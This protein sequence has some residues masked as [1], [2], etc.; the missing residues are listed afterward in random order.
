MPSRAD[1]ICGLLPLLLTTAKAC[2]SDL[3]CS[4]NGRCVSSNCECSDIWTGLACDILKTSQPARIESYGGQKNFASWGGNVIAFGGKFHLYVA[5][6]V[7]QCGL[8][9]WTTNSQIVHATSDTID[10]PFEKEDVAVAPWA[11]NPQIVH[12]PSHLRAGGGDLFVL[13]HIGD[14]TGSETRDCSKS[15]RHCAVSPSPSPPPRD[16]QAPF[17]TAPSPEGP[18]TLQHLPFDCNNPAPMLRTDGSW[19]LICNGGGWVLWSAPELAGPW[20]IAAKLSRPAASLGAGV[21]YEDPFL[22]EDDGGHLHALGHAY[23]N[24][25]P[26]DK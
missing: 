14:G 2:S 11:H 5:E 6:M 20:T 3:D 8:Q 7:G 22:W 12:V 24:T 18:W 13:F 9:T 17:H 26:C 4:L 15:L 16:G 21:H 1:F 19:M 25:T 23:N 10:G